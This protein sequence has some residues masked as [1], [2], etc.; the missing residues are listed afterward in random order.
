[1]VPHGD[2]TFSLELDE[3]ERAVLGSFITQYRDLLS[4]DRDD[5][6]LRRLFPAAYTDDSEAN[7]EYRRFMDDELVAARIAM[8]EKME[9]LLED[10]AR[11]ADDSLGSLMITVN[12]LRLVLGTALGI[13][14][15][16]WE[17]DFDEDDEDD[18]EVAQW[19]VYNWLGWLLE[20]VVEA[21]QEG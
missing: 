2:G 3:N 5:P 21:R 18:P 7:S 1:V 4:G 12:S 9:K 6:R 17:P 8:L 15:D 14:H 16:D 19:H 11:F 10:G 20:W 13:D